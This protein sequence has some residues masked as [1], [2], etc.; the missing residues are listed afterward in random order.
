MQQIISQYQ[1]R[2]ILEA[3]PLKSET[4]QGYPLSP[5][6]FNIVLEDLARAIRQQKEIKGIQIKKKSRY[7]YLWMIG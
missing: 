5:Y 3:I 1:I 7:H 6:L 4:R 2:E